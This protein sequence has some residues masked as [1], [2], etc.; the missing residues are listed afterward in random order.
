M[1][2]IKAHISDKSLG[3][4]LTNPKKEWFGPIWAFQCLFYE[5]KEIKLRGFS[6]L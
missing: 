5:S 2:E 6:C 4:C 1:L 3:V